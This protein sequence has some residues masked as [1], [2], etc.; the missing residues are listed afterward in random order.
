MKLIDIINANHWLSVELT[1]AQL[2]P[3]QEE[4][5]DECRDLNKLC[6]ML[7]ETVQMP[8]KKQHI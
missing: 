2:Y 3:D 7:R 6:L 1:L 8:T 5:L 4:M